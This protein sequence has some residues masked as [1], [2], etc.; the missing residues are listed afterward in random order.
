MVG[1]IALRDIQIQQTKPAI[2][3]ICQ[4]L[5]VPSGS[6]KQRL[7]CSAARMGGVVARSF[8]LALLNFESLCESD[9]ARVEIA[10]IRIEATLNEPRRSTKSR[11]I[12]L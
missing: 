6:A 11:G 10:L 12:T 1:R 3:D 8:G 9:R 7:R 5:V 2:R 4:S